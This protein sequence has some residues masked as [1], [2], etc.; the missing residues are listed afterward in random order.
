MGQLDLIAVIDFGTSEIRCVVG[1]RNHN[2]VISVLEHHSVSAGNS[3][4]R[5]II[6]N[7]ELAAGMLKKLIN[8]IHNKLGDIKIAKVYVTLGGQSVLSQKITKEKMLI[9]PSHVN[10]EMVDELW[11]KAKAYEPDLTYNYGIVDVEYFVDQKSEIRPVGVSCNKLE[12]DFTIA[13]GRPNL[14][15]NIKKVVESCG[16]ELARYYVSAVASAELLLEEQDRKLGCV[17]IDFGAGTTEVSVYHDGILRFISTIPLGGKSITHDITAMNFLEDEAE[18]YKLKFGK[19]KES[20]SKSRFTS[21]FSSKQEV[22]LVE[23]N[24]VIGYRLNEIIANIKE[25]IRLSGYED[26]LGAGVLITGAASKLTNIEEELSDKLKMDVRKVYSRKDKVNNA[27]DVVSNPS[28]SPALGTML[29]AK[30]N[31]QYIEPEP[32]IESELGGYEDGKEKNKT[33]DKKRMGRFGSKSDKPSEV[34]K[35]KDSSMK[36]KMRDFFENFFVDEMDDE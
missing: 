18:K 29:F 2:N 16:L 15:S 11:S 31:C 32:L 27:H 26:K 9:P 25:Q 19:A 20:K 21:P 4:R 17:L 24:K 30:E 14:L 34:K 1:K 23:L 35:T 33:P 3:V 5:G 10:Q 36:D 13:V 22:D 6:Y 8:T 28:F 12:A 7:V